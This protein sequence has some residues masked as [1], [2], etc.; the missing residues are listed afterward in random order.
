[1]KRVALVAALAGVI[2][3]GCWWMRRSTTTDDPPPAAVDTPAKPRPKTARPRAASDAATKTAPAAK[4]EDVETGQFVVRVTEAAN[5]APIAGASVRVA[6]EAGRERTGATDKDGVATFEKTSVGMLEI[7]VRAPGFAR[8]F[9]RLEFRADEDSPFQDRDVPF[10][11]EMDRGAAASGVVLDEA[12]RPIAGASATATEQRDGWRDD[13][14]P[15]L[16]ETTCGADGAF[17]LDGLPADRP[18]WL[19][20]SAPEYAV[21][22]I[23]WNPASQ[24][25]V[26]ARLV[27]AGTIHGVVRQPSN[28]PAEDATVIATRLDGDDERLDAHTEADGRYVFDRIPAKSRWKLVA[29]RDGAVDA[30][31]VEAVARGAAEPAVDLHLRRRPRIAFVLE[32]PDGSPVDD[33]EIDVKDREG[34]FDLQHPSK[35][36]AEFEI[37]SPGPCR[38][39]ID[40]AGFA[41]REETIDA[42]VDELKTVVVH[43]TRGAFVA[44]VV[45]DDVG[46]PIT[47]A[48]IKVVGKLSEGFG[49]WT[50]TTTSGADGAF[51]IDGLAEGKVNLEFAV[52]DHAPLD[53]ETSAPR[54]GVVV[55]LL[56]LARLVLRVRAPA[57]AT[58]LPAVRIACLPVSDPPKPIDVGSWT[59]ESEAQWRGATWT[60][61]EELAWPGKWLVV[62]DVAGFLTER[63]TVEAKAGDVVEMPE[64]VLDRGPQ[65]EGVVVDDVGRPV[66]GASVQIHDDG[67]GESDEAAAFKASADTDADGRFRVGPVARSVH[68]IAISAAVRGGD[69]VRIEHVD[70]PCGPQRIVLRRNGNAAFKIRDAAGVVVKARVR[71][72]DVEFDAPASGEVRVS[73][74]PGRRKIAVTA[75]DRAPAAFEIDVAPGAQTRLPDVVLD[76]GA[77]LTGRVVDSEGKPVVGADVVVGDA[78]ETSGED[79]RFVIEHVPREETQVHAF[80]A[81]NCSTFV[82]WKPDAPSPLVVV[83]RRG[84]MLNGRV[85]DAAGA[86]A[87]NVDVAIASK[88]RAAA[89]PEFAEAGL[90]GMFS[91]LLP[92][93]RWTVVVKRGGKTLAT[94]DFEMTEGAPLDLDVEVAK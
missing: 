56:R 62:V 27:R 12:G 5:G 31:P 29:S 23:E 13:S 6:D 8:T 10:Q 4:P 87:K 83:L 49:D 3:L 68:G 11:V 85:R 46:A 14:R 38:A 2:G 39:T 24:A 9:D 94:R 54:D 26:E 78:H 21:L 47:G 65:V 50:R 80:L 73:L 36:R 90:D 61:S 66:A 59:R 53:Y 69:V 71:V 25:R 44:G 91:T 42:A 7:V 77:T 28:R 37:V 67:S 22:A 75:A 32:A 82:A 30:D 79:G 52:K 86:L 51:R 84:G 89:A 16:A 81:G 45:V 18:C 88:D 76:A 35:G 93:G 64:I 33:A 57:D 70:F 74:A 48:T 55:P 1:M 63:R 17:R 41:P 15:S 43:L 34:R 19:A 92:A 20:F 40:A 72:D 58:R 60:D